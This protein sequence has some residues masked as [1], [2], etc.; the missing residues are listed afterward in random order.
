MSIG[1]TGY[2]NL[3]IDG[4]QLTGPAQFCG[5]QTFTV[6]EP[7][8]IN[9]NWT[10]SPSGIVNLAALPPNQVQLTQVTGVHGEITLTGSFVHPC[11]GRQKTF[12]RTIFAGLRTPVFDVTPLGNGYCQNEWYEAIGSSIGNGTVS[13]NWRINGLLDS[14][15]GY[16]IKRKFPSNTTTISL[17]VVKSGCA[18]SNPYFQTYVC[19]SARFSI[20]PNPSGNNIK[21]KALGQASF[22]RI[23]IADKLGLIKKDIQ[24]L[25]ESKQANINISGLP[26][27]IYSVQIFDGISWTTILLSVQR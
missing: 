4:V 12:T 22:N 11:D 3:A 7:S 8:G 27:D 13:Y 14:Y 15:H 10:V 5:T 20:S 23:R 1:V 2:Y 17:T 19:G 25:P 26:V 21:V 24:F 18:E 9:V 6:T 16:K